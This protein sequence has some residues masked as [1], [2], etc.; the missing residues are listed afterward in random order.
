[1]PA[2]RTCGP[3]GWMGGWGEEQ[4]LLDVH[5]ANRFISRTV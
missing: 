2:E 5:E 1:L 3:A 4:C